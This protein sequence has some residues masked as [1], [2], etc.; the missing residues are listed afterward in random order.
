MLFSR[1]QE[2]ALDLVHPYFVAGRSTR[3]RQGRGLAAF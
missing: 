1:L 3:H 2:T